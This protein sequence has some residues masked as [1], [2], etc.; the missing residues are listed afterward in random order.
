[1]PTRQ[2]GILAAVNS[3]IRAEALFQI[4]QNL[5]HG[6]KVHLVEQLLNHCEAWLKVLSPTQLAKAKR[7]F[8]VVPPDRFL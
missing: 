2:P 3:L 8:F 1:M 7:L 5:D 4:T 6:I